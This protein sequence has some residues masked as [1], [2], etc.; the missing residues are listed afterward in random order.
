MFINNI[1]VDK[2]WVIYSVSFLIL[3]IILFM[4]KNKVSPRFVLPFSKIS[5]SKRFFYNI[6][7]S[8]LIISIFLIP[9]DISFVWWKK[10]KIEK[11]VNVQILFDVSL[12]MSAKDIKPAR[13][14]AAK[15]SMINLVSNLSWYNVSL[16]NFSGIPFVWSPFSEDTKAIVSKLNNMSIADFPPTINFVWTAIWDALVL[17]IWNLEKFTTNEKFPWAIILI[18]DWD[19]NKWVDPMAATTIAITKNIPIYTLWI[20]QEDYIVWYDHYNIPV[21]TKINIP[22]LQDI[23][24]KSWWKFY[25]VLSEKDFQWIFDEIS[26]FIKSHEKKVI[27]FEYV[28]LNKY[29][30]ILVFVIGLFVL[31]LRL[32]IFVNI[33]FDNN[34]NKNGWN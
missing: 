19:S 20:W 31:V 4:V 16:I 30:Y 27:Y 15:D 8:I 1:L 23:S 3:L 18:T 34:S 12:S 10:I 25:R 6:S 2:N 32:Y 26:N 7:L 24:Q 29:L 9:L 22:L 5:S 13:F 11:T 17:W 28:N 14:D 33:L 21:T